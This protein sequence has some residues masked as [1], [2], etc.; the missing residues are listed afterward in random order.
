MEPSGSQS[1]ELDPS[2]FT[3]L[4]FGFASNLSPRTFQSRCPGSLYVGLSIL[5]GYRFLISDIGF[6]NVVPSDSDKDVVYGALYFLT[7]GHVKAMDQAEMHAT[8]D[9]TWHVK[10]T[11]RV[12]R[13]ENVDGEARE[14]E[15]GEVD[16]TTYIDV[17]HTSPGTIS[18]ENLT[19]IRRAMDDGVE[20]GVP[21]SYFETVWKRYLPEDEGV[22]RQEEMTMVRTSGMD[23]EEVGRYV[24][25]DVLK[26]AARE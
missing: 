6:G 13:L 18:K 1:E 22:G 5:R 25:R 20:C 11:V 2:Q 16:A 10:R 17:H 4:Y 19:F 15:G 14:V 7:A 3:C 26:L 12:Q 8:E 21:K 23:K 9:G 24:P